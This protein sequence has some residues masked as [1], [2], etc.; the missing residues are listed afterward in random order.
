MKKEFRPRLSEEEYNLILKN[1]GENQ[2]S[3]SGKTRILV[4]DIETSPLMGYVWSMWKQN[5]SSNQLISD[6]FMLTWSAKWLFNEEI[7]GDSLTREEVINQDDKRLTKGIWNLLDQA[8]IVI[9]HNG[10][11]FDL[12]S[13]NTRFLY[14]GFNNPSPYQ[15]ID[16]LK[17][18]R[19]QLRV[20]SNRLDYIG[21]FFDIGRKLEHTGFD[22]WSGFLK[23]DKDSMKLMLDYNKQ[24]VK[25]LEDVYLKLRPF[26]KPHPNLSLFIGDNIS[27]CPTCIS[28]QLEPAG[29]YHTYTN[30][31]EALRCKECGSMSRSRTTLTPLK[32]NKNL[33]T[34]LPK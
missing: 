30:V 7:F 32:E 14:H 10:D 27:R 9:A 34:P 12:R 24:D 1:R 4:F 29:E 6:W 28:D 23:G 19:K 31:Y 26:I 11:K 8:D 2:I 22:L 3:S 21:Q 20:S 15:S 25:L 33:K 17:H 18:A 5:V 13:L 16:T